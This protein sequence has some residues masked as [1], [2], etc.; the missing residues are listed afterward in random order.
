[1][2]VDLELEDLGG[3]PLGL[4]GGVRELDAA[5]LHPPAGEH[6]GLDDD[7][8]VDA[9]G[10]LARLCGGLRE[11]VF[12]DRDAGSLDQATGL[13]LVEA[14]RGAGAYRVASPTR[15]ECRRRTIGS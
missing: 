5:R 11:A 6:L 3:V 8:A 9:L 10:G 14:H 7:R 15:R 12:G 4:L 2:A 13:V 1:V